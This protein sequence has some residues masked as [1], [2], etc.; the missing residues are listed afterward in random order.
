MISSVSELP[1][2]LMSSKA[3]IDPPKVGLFGILGA[4]GDAD[5]QR[6][7]GILLALVK[8]LGKASTK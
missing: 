7:M 2:T 1:L 3:L 6:G 4:L 5:T 8:A